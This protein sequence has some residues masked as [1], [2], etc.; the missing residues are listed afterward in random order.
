[1]KKDGMRLETDAAYVATNWAFVSQFHVDGANAAAAD[2]VSVLAATALTA[3]TQNVTANITS[4]KT[5]RNLQVVGNA[6]GIVGN[7]TVHG[8][9]YDGK[10]ITEVFALNGTTVVIGNKAFMTVTQMDLPVQTHAGT[11]TVSV[12]VGSK[13]GLPYKLTFGIVLATYL[14]KA[15]E[16]TAP[17]LAMDASNVENNT[18]TLNSALNGN[19]VDV[20]LVV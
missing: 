17:T 2:T 9:G 5:P 11:D 10:P 20:F 8:T 6:A 13:L 15:K 7:V 3:A 12:G 14:N 1:M 4:P 16:G 18:I 19:D